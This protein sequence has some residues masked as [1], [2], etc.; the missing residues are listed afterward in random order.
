MRIDKWLWAARF[1][2]T[3]SLA[4]QAIEAGHVSVNHERAKPAKVL[5]AGDRVVVRRPPFEHTV[6]VKGLSDRR[7]GAAEAALLY[8][9][10]EESR[11]HRAVLAAQMKALPQP[12]FPGR[13]TKKTRRDYEKWLRSSDDE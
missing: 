9:E 8:E 3:R 6:L 7:G 4:V 1:F 12:R 13:P 10:T 2:R 11:A 5:K